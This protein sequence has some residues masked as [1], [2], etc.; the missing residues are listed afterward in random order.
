[1]GCE[2]AARHQIAMG[3][4][5]PCAQCGRRDRHGRVDERQTKQFYCSVCWAA[6]DQDRLIEIFDPKE[7]LQQKCAKLAQMI[8]SARYIIAFTGAGLSTGAGIMDFRSGAGTAVP[9]G[10]GLWERPKADQPKGNILEQCAQAKPGKSHAV[11][12]RMWQAG[13]LRHVISQNV[14][15]LHRK[16]GMPFEA[17]SE[18]HGNIFVER[19]LSCGAEFERDF[20]VIQP[21]N[22]DSGRRC[23]CGGKLRH[24]GVGF[25]EDLPQHVLK[26]A[27]DEAGKADLCLSLGSSLLVTPACEIPA[28][29]TK[30]GRLVIVNIQPTPLDNIASLRLNGFVDD[31]LAEVQRLLEDSGK[32]SS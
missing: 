1:M 26:K 2:E 21:G 4:I 9:T 12:F 15:G 16:S 17:L 8:A 11:L 28:W 19:C 18:L 20:N 32:L 25:G 22:P 5:P 13:L 14:D 23:H 31:V 29:V 10:P 7:E 27:W 3:R 6:Y 24:S 30:R